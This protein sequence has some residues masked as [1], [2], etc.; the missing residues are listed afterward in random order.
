MDDEDFSLPDSPV[1]ESGS[2]SPGQTALEKQKM[3]LQTYLDSL[4]YECE[5]V[6]EMQAKL[7]H[8]VAMICMCAETKN[9]LVLTTWDGMLQCW[10]LMHYPMPKTMRAKLV[11]LYYELCLVPGVEPRVVRSW[12]DMLARLLS[13]RPD[14]RRKLEVT[15]LQLPWRPLW[16]VLQKELWPKKRLHDPSR[17][18]I[19]ILLYVAEQCR[20]YF[21]ASDIP[22]M[23]ETFLPL[24]TK[25]VSVQC[26]ANA[27][28]LTPS[29]H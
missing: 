21:P 28:N 3:S 29:K 24:M 7:E 19:N 18:M 10:L 4:P 23:L 6:D 14:H 9:W 26:T 17:N 2:M 22:E 12:A 20:R 25:D 16:R 15:D 13:N 8:I 27:P 5:S 11:R 1:W